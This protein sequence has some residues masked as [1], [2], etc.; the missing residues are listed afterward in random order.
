MKEQRYICFENSEMLNPKKIEE[1]KEKIIFIIVCAVAFFSLCAVIE[2]PFAEVPN[3]PEGE[4]W[5]MCIAFFLLV[6]MVI[7]AVLSP[8]GMLVCSAIGTVAAIF[9]GMPAF[10]IYVVYAIGI[11]VLVKLNPQ[12]RDMIC[13]LWE[14]E[15]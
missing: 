14:E 13:S 5:P 8:I 11:S 6:T 3:D 15:K 1:M 7:A 9:C 2:S 10:V 4:S 12:V